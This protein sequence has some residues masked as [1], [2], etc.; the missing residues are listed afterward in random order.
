MRFLVCYP[1]HSKK[2]RRALPERLKQL[3]MDSARDVTFTHDWVST[4]EYSAIEDFSAVWMH[5]DIVKDYY[6]KFYHKL[7]RLNKYVPLIILSDGPR[8]DAQMC[9]HNNLLFSVVPMNQ[10]LENIDH[11]VTRLNSYQ[12]LLS[13]FPKDIRS[14]LRPNGFGPFI[15]NSQRMLKVYRQIAKVAATDFT[16]SIL[17]ES[18]S[19]KEL[20]AKTI[21]ELS[22]RK[23]HRFV[24]LN[25]A[26]IPEN[27]LESELFG[28]EKGAFTGANYLKPGKFELAHKG[29]IF[30]DEIGDMSPSLQAKLLRVLED[31]SVERLGGTTAKVVDIRLL[32]ATNQDLS[33]L[34]KEGEFRSDLHYRLNV[35]P[36]QLPPLSQRKEDILLLILHFLRKVTRNNHDLVKSIHWELI[37]EIQ[38]LDLSGNVRELKNLLI[39]I[40]FQSNGPVLRKNVLNEVVSPS[41]VK[42]NNEAQYT[43]YENDILPLWTIEK[44]AIERTLRE[45]KGN[46]SLTASHL[47]ISRT[48]LYKK[49]KKYH[50]DG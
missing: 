24:S 8:I 31:H 28:H 41:T 47:E 3:L 12:K 27:L 50:I 18:G 49:I 33:V 26:A 9:A 45:L 48:A 36:I 2:G 40:I 42:R 30:L 19:G 11:L 4:L 29:T 37:G 15:G 32:A 10:P 34:I 46:K 21:H 25:C 1:Y 17:G 5:W 44:M 22:P 23:N 43:A 39:Q 6:S 35:I 14:Y 20:M 7:S 16:V 13:E 38:N